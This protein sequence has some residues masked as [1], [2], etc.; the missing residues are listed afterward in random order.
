M[1]QA[2]NFIR[3]RLWHRYFPVNFAKFL[4]THFLQ[5]TSG[6]LLLF[7]PLRFLNTFSDD[8]TLQ[9]V[10]INFPFQITGPHL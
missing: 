10:K 6:R 2:C 9:D 1:S 3:K 4:R 7:L 8:C 5:K